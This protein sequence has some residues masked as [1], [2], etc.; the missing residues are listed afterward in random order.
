MKDTQN[1]AERTLKEHI[2]KVTILS[3]V[4]V[5]S[6]AVRFYQLDGE[7]LWMDEILQ[8]T[9]YPFALAEIVKGAAYQSQPPLD[10]IIGHFIYKI[11]PSDFSVRIP[12]A[13]FGVGTVWLIILLVS[14]FCAWEIAAGAGLIAG[15]MP[16]NIYFS[17]EARPYSIAIFFFLMVLWS[18]SRYYAQSQV[19]LKNV[20][21][22]FLFTVLFL[23]T[24]TLSPLIIIVSLLLIFALWLSIRIAKKETPFDESQKLLAVNM[25]IFILALLIMIPNYKL[26]LSFSKQYLPDNE[27]TFTMASIPAGIQKFSMIPLWRSFVTQCEPISV[28][29]AVLLMA[30]PVCFWKIDRWRLNK[31]LI[32]WTVL[33]P[34][35]GAMHLFIFKANTNIPFRAPYAI[36]ILPLII[37]LSAAVF[38]EIWMLACKAKL[39]KAIKTFLWVIV[40]TVVIYTAFSAYESKQMP[41]KPDWRGV[42][43][44]LNQSCSPDNTIIFDAFSYY[45]RFEPLFFGFSRYYTGKAMRVSMRRLPFISNQAAYLRHEPVMVFFKWSEYK[46]TPASRFPIVPY[47]AFA[48]KNI[49]YRKLTRNDLFDIK[50]YNGFTVI[51]LKRSS[52]DFI[53]DTFTLVRELI[54]NAPKDSSAVDLYLTA[55]RLAVILGRHDAKGYFSRALQIVETNKK[56][57]VKRIINRIHEK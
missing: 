15:L 40:S 5:I 29:F 24:R 38:Q 35:A 54:P 26:I 1:K 27:L 49:N 39:K 2:W 30:V 18:V 14:R 7:S 57:K 25:L 53:A 12:A 48:P 41:N 9:N 10:Y 44:Y 37:L 21:T 42:C 23:Q 34:L 28:V 4:L 13:L 55:G 6:I 19:R 45:D 3:I 51:K 11:S 50:D 8:V 56:D 22:V 43:N 33:L 36:Y 17:Q 46:L 20:L 16:F 52:G 47:P 32:V 31:D